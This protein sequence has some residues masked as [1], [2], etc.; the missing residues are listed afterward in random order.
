MTRWAELQ[1]AL[2]PRSKNPALS[3]CPLVV[4]WGLASQP[5]RDGHHHQWLPRGRPGRVGRNT[6]WEV[7]GRSPEGQEATCLG[8]CAGDG[9]APQSQS[10]VAP[11]GGDSG[12]PLWFCSSGLTTNGRASGWERSPRAR[13]ALSPPRPQP[14]LLP[15][16][17]SS[18]RRWELSGSAGEEALD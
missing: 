8:P 7:R 18:Q 14:L 10:S 16:W 4:A 15:L 12:C 11:R 2:L 1:W 3:L 6:A 13:L 5:R 17:S 9:V